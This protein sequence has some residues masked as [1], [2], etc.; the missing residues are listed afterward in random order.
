MVEPARQGDL[1]RACLRGDASALARA[2]PEF[3]VAEKVGAVVA[4]YVPSASWQVVRARD[5][6]RLGVLHRELGL[7]SA[8]LAATGLPFLLLRG[9]GLARYWPDVTSRPFGDVDLLLPAAASLPSVIAALAELGHRVVR[10]VPLLQPH[11]RE[12]GPWCGVALNKD[13]AD[14]GHPVYVDVIAPGPGVSR[15]DFMPLQPSVWDQRTTI[16]VDGQGV[17]ALALDDQALVFLL[18]QQERTAPLVRDALDA[19]YLGRTGL[20]DVTR[21]ARGL[22]GLPVQPLA[23]LQT[24]LAELEDPADGRWV[25][26]VE[27]ATVNSGVHPPVLPAQ[28]YARMQSRVTNEADAYAWAVSGS[29][30]HDTYN[31]GFPVYAFPGQ[32]LPGGGLAADEIAPGWHGWT[33]RALPLATEEEITRAFG[34]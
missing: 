9:P 14:L 12:T 6:A 7:M 5:A 28:E 22:A 16:A 3:A 24:L 13:V 26:E 21:V 10:P 31:S 34:P 33:A 30:V 2:A 32:N 25:A 19:V 11:H 29:A 8:R 17:P 15:L 27:Q 1:L 18:E 23:R 20:V 4:R